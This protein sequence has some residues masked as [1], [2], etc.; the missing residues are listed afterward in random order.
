M[1]ITRT[2]TA[3]DTHAYLRFDAP[4]RIAYIAP[5]RMYAI[6]VAPPERQDL[7]QR[8]LTLSVDRERLRIRAFRSKQPYAKHLS[9]IDGSPFRA[10]H[11]LTQAAVWR[12]D[13]DRGV[14]MPSCDEPPASL[15]ALRAL[16]Q[17]APMQRTLYTWHFA[18]AYRRANGDMRI[19]MKWLRR[20]A[21]SLARH[22]PMTAVTALP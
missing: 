5:R 12:V 22:A 9:A 7:D 1:T 2:C 4:T 11:V 19:A 10:T 15:D 21:A 14:F 18:T 17:R 16:L 20:E 8:P 6:Q 13:Y 3:C